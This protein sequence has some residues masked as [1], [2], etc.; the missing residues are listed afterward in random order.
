VQGDDSEPTLALP[1]DPARARDWLWRFALQSTEQAI[2][3]L[4]PDG[5]V[6]WANAGAAKVLGAP[7][8]VGR[9]VHAFFV[10]EDVGVPEFELAVSRERGWMQDDRWM[11]RIDGSR[12]WA[13]GITVAL[14]DDDGVPCGYAKLLRNQTHTRMQVETLRNRASAAH[15]ALATVAHEL[16]NPLSALAM[17]ANVIEHGGYDGE[18]HGAALAILQNNVR[19]ATRLID[20]LQDV[21]RGITGKLRVD[22]EPVSL[23]DVLRAAIAV[24]CGRDGRDRRV[25]LLVSTP[26]L[27]VPGDPL[28]LQQVFVNLVGNAL[29]YTPE[30]GRISVAASQVGDQALVEIADT[31]IGIAPDMLEAIFGMFTQVEGAATGSGMGIGLA[32]VKQIVELHGGSVQAQSDGLGKGSKFVVRLPLLQA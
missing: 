11:R 20:D 2:L 16:R 3:L 28:R 6:V 19:M 13:A 9:R 25:A 27:H 8:T 1:L 14:R 29:R 5:T 22:V 15:A 23:V 4:D 26:A 7:D 31:G 10:P 18:R 17:A 30:D 24:A 12:F 21:A 32:L